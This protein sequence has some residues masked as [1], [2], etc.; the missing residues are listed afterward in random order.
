MAVVTLGDARSIFLT[1]ASKFNVE[2]NGAIFDV[3]A[4]NDSA[5]LN[6]KNPKSGETT[7]THL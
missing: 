3:R 6:M 2:P 7:R 4:K 1:S 5:S